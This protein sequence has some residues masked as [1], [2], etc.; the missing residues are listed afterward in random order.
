MR[1]TQIINIDCL[2]PENIRIEQDRQ[3][4]IQMIKQWKVENKRPSW[5]Q[6][7][8]YGPELKAYWSA[9]EF[10]VLIDGILY[11]QKP[12]EKSVENTPRIVLPTKL[13]KKSFTALQ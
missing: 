10:L 2:M 7:A 9:W 11:K 5:S 4:E 8:Q 13:R 1:N 3:P 6:V 12:S